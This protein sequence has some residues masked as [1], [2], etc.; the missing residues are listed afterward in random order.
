MNDTQVCD[1]KKALISEEDQ[2]ILAT[3]PECGSTRVTVLTRGN[4]VR[5]P[6]VW[7]PE[8]EEFEIDWDTHKAIIGM[9]IDFVGWDW[10]SPMDGTEQGIFC[11]QC[12]NLVPDV[13]PKDAVE[14]EAF[15]QGSA[16]NV[17]NL[18]PQNAA[19]S[20]VKP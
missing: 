18:E 12:D 9:P 1:E 14:I 2:A 5:Y 7:L 11:E 6:L 10:S 19:E 17:P 4:I 20:E 3:C 8:W 13:K 15:C 16:S